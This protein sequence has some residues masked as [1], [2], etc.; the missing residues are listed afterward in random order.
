MEALEKNDAWDLVKFLNRRKPIGSNW[1]FKNNL[2][3]KGGVEKDM[4]GSRR[5]FLGG[6]NLF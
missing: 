5:I 6:E 4:L 2:N 3:P 1:L